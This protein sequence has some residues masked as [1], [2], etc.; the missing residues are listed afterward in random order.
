MWF[1]FDSQ[2]V[3][4]AL[5]LDNELPD[6]DMDSEDETLLNRLNRKM[7][8]KP[9]QFETMMDRLEKASTNQVMTYQCFLS[10]FVAGHRTLSG[11]PARY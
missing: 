8:L 6:Y 3:T 11:E 4:P 1:E 10:G 5:G 2:S 7:E 9:V